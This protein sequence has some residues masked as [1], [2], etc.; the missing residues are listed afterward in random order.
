MIIFVTDGTP[1]CFFTAVYDAFSES[2]CRIIS[3]GNFQLPLGSETVT[4]QIDTLKTEKVIRKINSLDGR[5]ANDVILLLKS[6][7]TRKEQ[8]AFEY[9][10]KLLEKKRPI[11]TAY[12]LPEV[13]AFNDIT[14]KITR[15]TDRFRGF[16]RFTECADGTLYAPF[17]PDNDI[18]ENLMPHF[19][20]RFGR[21][22]FII[23]DLSREKAGV[24]NGEKWILIR[25][26]QAEI[27][28]SANEKAFE[29]LWKKYYK[30]VNIEARLHEKQMKG[31]MPVRYW[32]FLPEKQDK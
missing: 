17:S 25:A 6:C 27:S 11:D 26:D 22:K 4:V 5:A 14:Y 30:A 24:Y 32:K 15:E 7:D 31:Y 1:E 29:K 10:K 28:L 9:I 19:A 21:L 8:V 23:H 20:A 12:N 18:T 2:D 13:V 3:D 16:L